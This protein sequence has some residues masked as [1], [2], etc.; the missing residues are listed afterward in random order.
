MGIYAK[1][2]FND[3]FE[4][5]PAQEGLRNFSFGLTLGF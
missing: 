5:S 4:N 2:Y 1:Y 3:M